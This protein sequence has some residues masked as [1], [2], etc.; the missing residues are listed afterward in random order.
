MEYEVVV[1][2][3]ETRKVVHSQESKMC[4]EKEIMKCNHVKRQLSSGSQE[5][6]TRRSPG[7]ICRLWRKSGREEYPWKNI[8]LGDVSICMKDLDAYRKMSWWKIITEVPFVLKG[9]IC[10]CLSGWICVGLLIIRKD[11]WSWD[12][13]RRSIK[14][15]QIRNF[16]ESLSNSWHDS[17]WK[18]WMIFTLWS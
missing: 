4:R 14:M 16:D 6:V 17:G 8:S 9:F 1:Y 15:D 12:M 18:W 11:V 3:Q 13:I 10:K 2:E 5:D 7:E